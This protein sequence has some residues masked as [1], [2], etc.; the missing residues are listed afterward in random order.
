MKAIRKS[1][2]QITPISQIQKRKI[3][4]FRSRIIPVLYAL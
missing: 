2:P 3:A 1:T 4:A